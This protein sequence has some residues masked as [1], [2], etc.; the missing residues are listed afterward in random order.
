[1]NIPMKKIHTKTFGI[2]IIYFVV[3]CLWI[4]FTD[5]I[6]LHWFSDVEVLTYYQTFK[7]WFYVFGTTVLLFVLINRQLIKL[8]RINTE[9]K[10]SNASKSE[11]LAKLNQ[12]QLNAKIGSWDWNLITGE[13]WWS[14]QMY[15]I[16]AL[17]T[18]IPS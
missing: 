18:R 11:V 16:L 6:F 4:L 15:S 5:R 10:E 3:G 12:A 1:M 14:D 17:R 9:L 8:G 7:G 2:V 13:T